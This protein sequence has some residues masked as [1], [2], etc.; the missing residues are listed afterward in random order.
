[1][2][3]TTSVADTTAPA[4][5]ATDTAT[6]AGTMG[7]VAHRQAPLQPTVRKRADYRLRCGSAPGGSTHWLRDRSTARRAYS[8][9]VAP[10]ALAAQ[11]EGAYPAEQ[12]RR[13]CRRAARKGVVRLAG[14][15]PG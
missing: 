9:R 1:M 12:L 8:E 10:S 15:A 3:G 2:A 13:E 4:G 7:M 6:A 5:T 11:R 14:L